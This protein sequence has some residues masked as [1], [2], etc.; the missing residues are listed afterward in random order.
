MTLVNRGVVGAE[1]F[2]SQGE[3][4]GTFLTPAAMKR[5]FGEYERW[6]L[7]RG[8]GDGGTGTRRNFRERLKE[9]VEG[10]VAA[11]RTGQAFTP[12]RFDAPEGTECNTSS[13]TI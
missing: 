4:A 1:D 10:L 8:A 6:M 3:R 12:Y 2:R 13:V 7:D 5:F 11:L 9:D